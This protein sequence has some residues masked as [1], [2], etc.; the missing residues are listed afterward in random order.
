VSYLHAGA[1][2]ALASPARRA[3]FLTAGWNAISAP[4]AQRK[5]TMPLAKM[6][7]LPDRG[8]VRVAG[9]DAEKFLNGTITADLDLL[10]RQAAVHSALLTPQGKMLFEFFVTKAPG[11]EGAFLLETGGD[12]A[13]GL[14]KRLRMYMLRAKVTLEDV[15]GAFAVAAAWDGPPPA[16]DKLIVY[17]DPRLAEMGFRVL[18]P[19]PPGFAAG[20]GAV[21]SAGEWMTDDDYHAHRIALGVPEAGKDFAIGDTFPHEADLD[22]LNGVSFEKGCFIGQ[23]VVSRMRH[24][25]NVRK[26]VVPVEVLVEAEAEAPLRSGAPVMLGE[27]EIGRIGSV[28]GARAL[29]LIRLDRAAEAAAKGQALLADGVAVGLRKPTWATFELAPAPPAAGNP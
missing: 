10:A 17:E 7:L 27:A 26:R 25:G 5:D 23:E 20:P 18:A 12:L 6:A 24:R 28:A 16:G 13:E 21:E 15:S 1:A 29:A 11:G 4:Q 22:L 19:L 8:V 2:Q 9:P 3:Y 14:V